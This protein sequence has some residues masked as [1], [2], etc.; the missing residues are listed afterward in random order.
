VRADDSTKRAKRLRQVQRAGR[1]AVRTLGLVAPTSIR[2]ASDGSSI[3]AGSIPLDKLDQLARISLRLLV[4]EA[5]GKTRD[6]ALAKGA[7]A[8]RQNHSGTATPAG[9]EPDPGDGLCDG[10]AR[11]AARALGVLARHG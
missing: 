7:S 3:A 8:P 2:H 4:L 6:S 11:R 1:A 9:F 10:C 5:G